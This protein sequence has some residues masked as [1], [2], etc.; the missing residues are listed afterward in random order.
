MRTADTL[1]DESF[2]EVR[3]KLLEVA[4]TLDRVDRAAEENGPLSDA[5]AERLNRV[6]DAI[7]IVLDE[8]PDRA[9][10]L[11]QLFSRPFDPNWRSSM[12]L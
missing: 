11:Q 9:E 1:L 8:T 7:R 5:Q 12:Q 10:Q 4:A 3:S 2:L 6:N